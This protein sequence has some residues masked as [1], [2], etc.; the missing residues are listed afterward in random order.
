MGSRIAKR[1][2]DRGHEVVV[3]NREAAK[4]EPLAAAGAAVAESP[5]E[6]ARDSA[7]VITMVTGPDALRAVTEGPDG[8]LARGGTAALIQMSTVGTEAT[9]RLAEAMPS[10]MGLLDAPVLGS[11]TEAENGKLKLYAGGPDDL[12][13]RWTPL[14]SDLGDVLHVGPVGA[15]SAAKLVVNA[16]LVGVIAVLGESL[17]LGQAL[18][19]ERGRTFEI[20]ETTA[21]AEQA[22]R[23]RPALESREF[24]SRFAL[25][26]AR[27]DGDLILDADSKLR[28]IAAAREW[29]AEAERA[30]RAGDDYSAVLAY[31]LE[32]AA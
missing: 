1:L 21:L 3:W 13:E 30:G 14:L 17:A 2:L 16:V 6:A 32:S 12:L 26:L 18:G 22:R 11:I 5:A 8:V 7:A 25:S 27:K 29:L 20:L 9:K 10:S 4:T 31:I 23:R 24:P 15:G 19:L 28:V